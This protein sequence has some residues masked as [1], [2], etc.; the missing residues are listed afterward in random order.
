MG[1]M[2]HPDDIGGIS[3]DDRVGFDIRS[4]HIGEN[5]MER[6]KRRWKQS[7]MDHGNTF[8]YYN[9]E[10][11]S[12][13]FSKRDGLSDEELDKITK[14]DDI[15]KQFDMSDLDEKEDQTTRLALRIAGVVMGTGALIW[16]G[17]Q[18]GWQ[19]PVI[20]VLAMWANNID[21]KYS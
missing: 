7:E 10:T 17:V 1:G 19:F 18:Y 3:N 9:E 20:G 21:R 15:R 11:Q 5:G 16:G 6:M 14:L 2:Y 8:F 4:H 12:G 13:V